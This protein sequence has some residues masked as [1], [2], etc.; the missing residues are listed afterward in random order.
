MFCKSMTLHAHKI[1]IYGTI[2]TSDSIQQAKYIDMLKNP[3]KILVLKLMLLELG[4]TQHVWDFW[5]IPIQQ[6]GE[7]KGPWCTVVYWN[8]N[9]W[10]QHQHI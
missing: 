8:M 5:M 4:L 10:K 9:L 3:T 1:H 6:D 2:K 7:N